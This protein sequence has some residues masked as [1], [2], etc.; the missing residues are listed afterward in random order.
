ME[1]KA[2]AQISKRAFVQSLLILLALMIVT[3][4]LTLVI[5]AGSYT[6]SV[7]GEQEVVKLPGAKRRGAF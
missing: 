5:P 1:Q 4:V 2:S 6:R 7:E 3:G